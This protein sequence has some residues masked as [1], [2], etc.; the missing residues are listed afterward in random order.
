MVKRTKR[1]GMFIRIDSYEPNAE[2]REAIEEAE[3]IAHDPNV[4]SYK[5][6]SELLEEV[7]AE[8]DED[9]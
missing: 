4:K 9:V 7:L 6:F 1:A 8:D 2:T 3:R 5:N